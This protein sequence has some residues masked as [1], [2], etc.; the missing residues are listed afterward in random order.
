M[1]AVESVD[2]D[3]VRRELTAEEKAGFSKA[4]SKVTLED[5]LERTFEA[6][7]A[8]V[9][10]GG[11]EEEEAESEEGAELRRQILRPMIAKSAARRFM[12]REVLRGAI[13][14]ALMRDSDAF[15]GAETEGAPAPKRRANQ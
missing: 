1:V 14:D 2:D 5:I 9:L 15:G 11:D 6:G 13:L 3:G 12:K 4:N 8:T 7:I 10:G